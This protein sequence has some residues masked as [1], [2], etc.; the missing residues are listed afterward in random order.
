MILATHIVPDVESIA[1]K[2]LLLHKGRLI[3]GGSPETLMNGLSG[4]VAV[5]TTECDCK[6]EIEK[7]YH[8]SNVAVN[9]HKYQYRII[10]D[11]TLPEDA[12]LVTPSLEDVFLLHTQS[13]EE[14]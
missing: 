4:K 13:G 12:V 11:K 9:N 6:A 3:E 1:S 10:S 14:V 2:V 7:E 8:I 5:I